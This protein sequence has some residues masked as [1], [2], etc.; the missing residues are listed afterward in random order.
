MKKYESKTQRDTRRSHLGDLMSTFKVLPSFK[1]IGQYFFNR[2][3]YYGV[4]R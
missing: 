1:V 4:L 3:R 2:T